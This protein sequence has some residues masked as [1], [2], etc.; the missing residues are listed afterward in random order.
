[1]YIALCDMD[2]Q[3]VCYR[4]LVLK[5]LYDEEMK[6]KIDNVAVLQKMKC[7]SFKQK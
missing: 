2:L 4:T 6:L 3:K 5:L 7:L 1:M